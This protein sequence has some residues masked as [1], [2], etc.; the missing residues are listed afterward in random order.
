MEDLFKAAGIDPTNIDTDPAL[1]QGGGKRKLQGGRE[2]EDSGT[3]GG[4]NL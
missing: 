2:R 1:P 4:H 3:F